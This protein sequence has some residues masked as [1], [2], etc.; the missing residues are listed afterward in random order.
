LSDDEPDDMLENYGGLRQSH[1]FILFD[2]FCVLCSR[3]C[4]FVSR[5]DRKLYFRYLAMQSPEGRTIAASLGINPDQP[6]TFAFIDDGRT[7]QKSDAA[8][9]IARKL[10]G[11]R[12]I[13]VLLVI[14]RGIRDAIYDLIAR[15]RYRW[16]GRYDYC[17]LPKTDGTW[18]QSS[19]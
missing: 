2:G 15:N 8:I 11:W 6:H 9:R 3:G 19:E 18:P 16:F 14:P 4:R 7:W 1:G 5:R 17:L 13:S 12:W 10:P